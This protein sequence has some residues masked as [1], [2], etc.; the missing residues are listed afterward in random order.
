LDL[1]SVIRLVEQRIGRIDRMDTN[2]DSIEV[3]WPNDDD[4]YSLKGDKR[5]INTS[6]FVNST[7]GGNFQIPV[8]L[9]DRHFDNV[10]DIN[11]MQREL[12]EWKGEK[13]WEGSNNFF[14]PIEQLKEKFI[15]DN[16]YELMRDV[17]AQ[18][19]TQVSFY[20]SKSSWCFITTRGSAKE[21][22][23][24]IFMELGKKPTSNFIE[25][26]KKLNKIFGSEQTLVVVVTFMHPLF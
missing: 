2:H 8:E 4:E 1:P 5:L 25:V 9:R 7:I 22:P 21:S 14:S 3:L 23:K 19:R 11:A 18:V 24:W 20:Q 17:T 10:D 16:L 6:V 12:E 26:S 13:G 15:D